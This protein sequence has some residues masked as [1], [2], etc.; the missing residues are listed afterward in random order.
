MS[1]AIKLISLVSLSLIIVTALTTVVMASAP[2][3]S[4]GQYI[5]NNNEEV[6]VVQFN[7]QA[8]LLKA[9]KKLEAIKLLNLASNVAIAT[10]QDLEE[11]T[12][13][14]ALDKVLSIPCT[15][16]AADSDLPMNTALWA[17]LNGSK[18]Y[19]LQAPAPQEEGTFYSIPSRC[20]GLKE[21]FNIRKRVATSGAFRGNKPPA[22]ALLK[23]EI[24][25]S[26][27][28]G[29]SNP[30]EQPP[31]SG[32][33]GNSWK[34]YKA[35]VAIA[36][37][38]ETVY[39]ALDEENFLGKN[40]RS[41]LSIH[42]IDGQKVSDLFWE[43]DPEKIAAIE[44]KLKQLFAIAAND[45]IAS[46]APELIDLTAKFPFVEIC[47]ES[48]N[49][50]QKSFDHLLLSED[51]P[52]QPIPSRELQQKMNLRGEREDYWSVGDN[53]L[54]QF[55]GCQELTRALGL[56]SSTA[57]ATTPSTTSSSEWLQE[58]Y[59]VIEVIDQEKILFRCPAKASNSCVRTFSDGQS[60]NNL[61]FRAS[62][63]CRGKTRLE[64][65]IKGAVKVV[66]SLILEGKKERN[67]FEEIEILGASSN[68]NYILPAAKG[69]KVTPMPP[70]VCLFDKK[71]PL[72]LA[73][74]LK[75][76]TISNLTITTNSGSEDTSAPKIDLALDI[77]NSSTILSQ[78]QI[79]NGGGL[80]SCKAEVYSLAS[81][82]K[83]SGI[84]ILAAGTRLLLYGQGVDAEEEALR[85]S[86]GT[87]V[88]L[89]Q[90]EILAP[91]TAFRLDRS[92]ISIQKSSIV[93]PKRD[94]PAAKASVA[95][96][97]N[98]GNNVTV[99]YSTVSGFEY[100]TYF[101]QKENSIKFLLPI[102]DLQSENV[103][104]S[105]GE[106]SFEIIE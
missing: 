13:T 57:T 54:L 46:P 71:L 92:E 64:L 84:A 15:G 100:L 76:L 21:A 7:Q 22:A 31:S 93:N 79:Q 101:G 98:K 70:S 83:S 56:R 91:Q 52:P 53:R 49:G 85:C 75:K 45:N 99:D 81:N 2:T 90:G 28:E 73:Q 77:Q 51:L 8:F 58:L 39:I 78:M 1:K 3:I 104:L 68:N 38:L 74:D 105:S 102:T 33:S 40:H 12:S 88:L 55:Y 63:E 29:T 48:C 26:C 44:K 87:T 18:K 106:G 19:Y 43:G 61:S 41:L 95:F 50:P 4:L 60:L 14:F 97:M 27:G 24:P 67:G 47:L 35:E 16:V 89:Y 9:C 36:D 82:F 86:S 20:N 30:S 94:L 72:I 32:N 11:F 17:D 10:I 6:Y 42:T 59:S 62:A 103:H 80:R 65:R 5:D 69:F 66:E 25:L 23:Q 96:K 34:L 37:E